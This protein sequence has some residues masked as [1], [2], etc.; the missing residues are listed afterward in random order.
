MQ[1]SSQPTYCTDKPLGNEC[2]E[3]AAYG[4]DVL[5]K[6]SQPEKGS[7]GTCFEAPFGAYL[8]IVK[9]GAGACGAGDS[10][11]SIYANVGAGQSLCTPEYVGNN[12]ELTRQTISHVTFC[13]CPADKVVSQ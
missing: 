10:S 4:L 13:S 11:Y 7:W 2:A 9:T 12:G 8:A 1:V 6:V 3:F 5:A